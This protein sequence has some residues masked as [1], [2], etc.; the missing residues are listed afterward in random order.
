MAKKVVKKSKKATRTVH[1]N[2]SHRDHQNFIIIAGGGFVIMAVMFLMTN[3]F[4]TWGVSPHYAS[5]IEATDMMKENVVVIKD[6]QFNPS[7]L[8]VKKGMVVTFDNQDSIPHSVVAV[9]ESFDTGTIAKGE[10]ASV[11]FENAGTVEYRSA[12]D[13]LMSGKVVVEE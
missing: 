1:L 2:T 4:G 9:D 11:V 10:K 13:P 5:K 12:S 3:G 6:A 7:S 8:T